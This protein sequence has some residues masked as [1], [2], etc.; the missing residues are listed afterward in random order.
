[1]DPFNFGW[2][3]PGFVVI[4]AALIWLSVIDLRTKT[5]PRRIIYLTAALGLPWLALQSVNTGTPGSLLTSLIGAAAGLIIFGSVHLLTKGALGAGDV[6]M[7]V[8]LGAVLGWINPLLA[9]LGLLF[10]L[11]LAAVTGLILIATGRLSRHEPMAL[12][13]FL[14]LGAF[15]TVVVVGMTSVDISFSAL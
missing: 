13:P 8:L 1:M 15:L 9:P 10:G 3:L 4:T 12:G 11:V 5:L 6:R 7:A 14:N 2:H